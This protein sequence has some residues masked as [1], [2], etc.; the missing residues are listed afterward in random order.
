MNKLYA[1]L[2]ILVFL[3]LS[4][5]E[6][7]YAD[8]ISKAENLIKKSQTATIREE[9]YEYLNAAREL[10]K[11]EYDKNPSNEKALIGL[12]KVYQLTGER[13]EAKLFLLKAYN[14][15]PYDAKLQR[16]M[17]DFYFSFQEYSTAIE[18]YKL[19]LAT[20]L[21]RDFDTNLKTAKCYE[22]LGDLENAELYFKI[23]NQLDSKSKSVLKK[24]NE[25]DSSHHEDNSPELENARYKYLYKDKPLTPQE[26]DDK[27][28]EEIIQQLN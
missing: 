8:N 25:Y 13:Q 19:A 4:F 6:V 10:Y 15:R 27:D 21:L 28:V 1:N 12:S 17:A 2:I 9:K 14:V 18:Y 7:T 20:G 24:L 16:E 3:L 26:Q 5:A 11:K 22:K 23:C